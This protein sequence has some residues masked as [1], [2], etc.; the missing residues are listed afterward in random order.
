MVSIAGRAAGLFGWS[1]YDWSVDYSY[2]ASR[3]A[4]LTWAQ[5]KSNAAQAVVT[6]IAVGNP[7]VTTGSQVG[8][9]WGRSAN[10]YDRKTRLVPGPSATIKL[11]DLVGSTVYHT[12]AYCVDGLGN[13]WIGPDVVLT[14]GSTP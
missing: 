3:F 6:L 1:T 2:S 13:T 14:T 8:I 12:A 9:L 10:A 7:A 5:V 4:A 11:T